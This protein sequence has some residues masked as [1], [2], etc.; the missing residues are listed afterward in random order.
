MMGWDWHHRA[1]ASTGLLF[2]PRWSRCEPWYDDIN[3][4]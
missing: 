1:A 3:W 2:I 4:G